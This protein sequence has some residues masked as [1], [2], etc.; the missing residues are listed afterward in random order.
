MILNDSIVVVG[1]A[2]L[3]NEIGTAFGVSSMAVIVLIAV[4]SLEF[5]PVSIGI[6]WL[7][8]NIKASYVVFL[9]A[10]V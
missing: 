9:G 10:L 4:P 6:A 2:A 7:F 3:V 8:K 1:F 5:I